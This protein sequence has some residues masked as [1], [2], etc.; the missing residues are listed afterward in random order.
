MRP[1][2]IIRHKNP[3]IKS[4]A[5]AIGYQAF[6]QSTDDGLFNAAAAGELS[7]DLTWLLDYLELE[8]P[9]VV[10][11]VST[12]VEDLLDEELPAYA[13]P[14]TTMEEL[15]LFMRSRKTK[16]LPVVDDQKGFLGLLTI[17]DIAMLFLESLGSA[18]DVERSPDIVRGLLAKTAGQMMKTK[19][20]VL[21]E[22][23]D[24]VDEAR[25]NMLASRY[26][27][28]PVVDDSNRFLGM[29]SRYNLLQMKRKRVILVD[30]NEKKQA[31]EGIEE[32]EILE[33][34]D[35]H[36]V[37]DL[38]TLMPIFFHNE[39]VGSTSTLV[40]D[41]FLRNQVRLDAQRA[42]LLLSG[43]MSDTMIFGSP[44]TTAKDKNIAWELEKISGFD[45]MVWGKK[46]YSQ[47]HQ[48]DKA[49]DAE[50]VNE[51]L[52]E[53]ASGDTTFAISQVETVELK[54]LAP[55]R[56]NLIVTMEELCARRGYALMCLMVTSI[57][58]SGTEVI[59]AGEKKGLVEDAFQNQLIDGSIFLKGVLSR[60][61]QVVPVIYQTLHKSSLL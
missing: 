57:F 28:Y 32:A 43:I 31:V 16:T 22:P 36:R 56:A 27:N 19:G 11:D 61:K 42:A 35:H 1:I 40:A 51:D 5:S 18:Q 8:H 34:V 24:K 37:G 30:H 6:K 23:D 58:E 52:K 14:E 60:K 7:E 2:Y 45:A 13:G 55:R 15:G 17:G 54:A 26:R 41:M 9:V 49:S 50:L 48:V 38:Q 53:Y 20:V 39:P 59:V 25:R 21:F 44:T 47:I 29:I 4:I 12:R 33:I 3:D 46:L 10:K